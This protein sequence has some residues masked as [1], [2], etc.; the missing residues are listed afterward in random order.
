M[1]PHLRESN[2]LGHAAN[3]SGFLRTAQLAEIVKEVGDVTG[4]M[5]HIL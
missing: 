5:T 3:A 1:Q 2:Q 4:V